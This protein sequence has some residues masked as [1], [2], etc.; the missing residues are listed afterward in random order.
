MAVIKTVGN[1]GQIALGK[2]YAGRHVMVEETQPVP[3]A[4]NGDGGDRPFA[5]GNPLIINAI[6]PIA[7]SASTS[8]T[9]RPTRPANP[10]H[11][12]H[13][14]ASVFAASGPR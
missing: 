9:P 8:M 4:I 11:M 3:F 5:S 12:N 10:T 1:S 2:Q 6:K 14:G 13:V 7:G